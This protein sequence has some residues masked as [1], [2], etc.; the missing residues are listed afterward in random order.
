MASKT[1]PSCGAKN[2]DSAY[3]CTNC[4]A[5]LIDSSTISSSVGTYTDS[6]PMQT[7]LPSGV[8]TT[9]PVAV[10]EASFTGTLLN[11]LI[12]TIFLLFFGLQATGGFPSDTYGI[13]ASLALALGVPLL[14]TYLARSRFDFYDTHFSKASRIRR[15]DYSYSDMESVEKW[16]GGL[17]V[18]LKQ[19]RG[20]MNSTVIIPKN[21]K[22]D[23]GSDLAT[24]LS[25][26]IPKQT[27][28]ES[29]SENVDKST[30]QV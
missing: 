19:E 26:K 17:R 22:L 27:S 14:F 25:Q 11:A 10:V 8:V 5:S 18:S 4:A 28:E 9:Q 13:I 20:F 12:T 21:P 1:C 7:S 24:F 2:A 29:A 6:K 15:R 16:R 23:S 3:I 30:E